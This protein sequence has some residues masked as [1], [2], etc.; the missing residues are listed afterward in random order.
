MFVLNL[1]PNSF[2]GYPAVSNHSLFSFFVSFIILHSSITPTFCCVFPGWRVRVQFWYRSCLI[3]P[4]FPSAVLPS[5]SLHI[6]QQ[7][8]KAFTVWHSHLYMQGHNQAFCFFFIII[9]LFLILLNIVCLL[10]AAENWDDV[11]RE[12]IRIAPRSSL[13]I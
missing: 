12:L 9:I 10:I 1:L 3:P 6:L 5:P 11:F 7:F 4:T 2:L 8:H 13:L